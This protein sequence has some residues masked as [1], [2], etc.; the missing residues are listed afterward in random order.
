M[1]P[2]TMSKQEK[3]RTANFAKFPLF[4]HSLVFGDSKTKILVLKFLEKISKK[5][6]HRWAEPKKSEQR[7][8]SSY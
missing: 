3:N 7:A 4:N 1:N 8:C 5:C 2:V 6:K